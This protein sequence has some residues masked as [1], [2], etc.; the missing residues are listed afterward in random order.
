MATQGDTDKGNSRY[1][2]PALDAKVTTGRGSD[3]TTGGTNK[4]D[5][6]NHQ[7]APNCIN[8]SGHGG[9]HGKS[10]GFAG[11]GGAAGADGA[12]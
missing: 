11:S 7:P 10:V 2:D 3:Q 9:D 12:Q 1:Y 5:A 8:D 4:P 6:G